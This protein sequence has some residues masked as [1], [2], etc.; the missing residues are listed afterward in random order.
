MDLCRCGGRRP[1]RG[2]EVGEGER[3]PLGFTDMHRGCKG[4]HLEVL[5]W[6]RERGCPWDTWTC[7]RAAEGGHLEVLQWA[8]ERGCP[9]DS[10]T[11][12]YAAGGGHLEV[13]K[14]AICNGRGS[15][16]ALGRR[17]LLRCSRKRTPGNI[18]VGEGTRMPLG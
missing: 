8:R 16:D 15:K 2:P 12:A 6:A 17:Y 18:K 9:W 11:C 14:W 3:M 10:R 13:L 1:F 4:G 5:K 7:I